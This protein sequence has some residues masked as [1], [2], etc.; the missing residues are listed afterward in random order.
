MASGVRSWL[1]MEVP[2]TDVLPGLIRPP[3]K[4]LPCLRVPEDLPESGG[5]PLLGGFLSLQDLPGPL[6]ELDHQVRFLRI[7]ADFFAD[8]PGHGRRPAEGGHRHEV[9][10]PLPDRWDDDITGPARGAV[11]EDT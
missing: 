8:E 2:L 10:T 3:G 7:P 11:A 4:G 6:L 9:G 5:T 1:S